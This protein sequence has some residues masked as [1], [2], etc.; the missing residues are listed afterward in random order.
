MTTTVQDS[1]DSSNENGR[2]RFTIS[3]LISH[4]T[5]DAR[6]IGNTLGLEGHFQ[7][8]A[9]EQMKTP[10]GI[11]LAGS[12]YDT[13]WRHCTR[14]EVEAQWFVAQL[15]EFV[16][17][18][19]PHRDFFSDV[20][21]AGGSSSLVISFLGDGYFGDSLSQASLAKIV[22]MNLDLGFEIFAVRQT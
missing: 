22:E 8:S 4:P 16:E 14:Y 15:E 9:G 6:E 20:R 17:Q 11:V 10:A 13:R 21:D 19:V 18:L 3:L 1:G 12:Y 5:L 2:R 7:H